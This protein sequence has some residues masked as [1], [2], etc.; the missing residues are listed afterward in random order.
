MPRHASWRGPVV[1]D[2]APHACE[3]GSVLKM[4]PVQRGNG[5]CIKACQH[6]TMLAC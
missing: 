5:G 4:V 1:I 6:V 3:Y 2:T